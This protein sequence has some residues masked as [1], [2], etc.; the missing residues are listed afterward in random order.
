MLQRLDIHD[1]ALIED[2]HIEWGAGLNVLTGETGAGKSIII[3]A[4]NIVLGGRAAATDIRPN[5]QRAVIEASFSLTKPA[6]AWLKFQELPLDDDNALTIAREISKTGSRARVN[7]SLVNVSLLQE[8]RQKL[9][10]IHTQHEA[11][12]LLAPQMQLE[13]LDGLGATHSHA[14]LDQVQALFFRWREIKTTLTQ[15]EASEQERSQRLDYASFQ[16]NELE[17]AALKDEDEFETVQAAL[18]RLSSTAQ[19]EEAA[20][21]AGEALSSITESENKRAIDLVQEAIVQIERASQYDHQLAQVSDPLHNALDLLEQASR[22]LHRYRDSLQTDPK[23]LAELESRLNL[24][25]G[26]KRK[27]GPTL[28]DAINRRDQLEKEIAGLTNSES[29]IAGLQQELSGIDAQLTDY[30]QQLSKERKQLAAKLSQSIR[31]ELT[32]LGM[33]ACKFEINFEQIDPGPTGIDKVEML[34]SPNPGQPLLPVSKIASGGELSRVML[35]L[36]SIF[37]M[38]D[39]VATVVFDEIDT[40]LSG[41]VLQSVRDKLVKLSKSHQI[42]CITHQPMIAS[43][44]DN[45]IQINKTH[46]ADS[47]SISVIT[48]EQK[49]RVKIVASMA[50]G[51]ENQQ[52]ALRFAEALLNDATALRSSR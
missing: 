1:F 29:T 32:D 24:L 46:S 10:T 34:I 19:L 22:F 2:L 9:L 11:R 42:L 31:N 7:G 8:L 27:Y 17:Q 43:V 6:A 12:S 5:A 14:L 41:K 26:I 39:K 51:Y 13:L 50:S 37:A 35:A 48:L 20:F 36:K 49:E 28:T 23:A 25:A 40:G 16:Y 18:K 45:H 44:A 47:T 21:A 38:A 4:L 15:L 30:C 33:S 3:D 52:E